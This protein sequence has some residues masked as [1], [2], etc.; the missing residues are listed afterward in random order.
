[1]R[2]NIPKYF[3]CDVDGV[4][5][6]GKYYYTST[7]KYMKIFGPHDSDGLKMIKNLVSVNFVSADK[8]GFKISKKRI[9]NDM[10]YHL[11]YVNEEDRYNYID[12]KYGLQ[13]SIY[14]GDGYYDSKILKDCLFGIVPK[15]AR[16]EAKKNSDFI[17]ESN[18]SD[19]AVLD[20]CIK[21][22]KLFFSK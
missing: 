18:G 7:G 22:I 8:R 3:I 2:K 12:K 13:N 11:A 6:D 20:A 5:T 9:T 1:M 19:G 10:G 21:I 15:N 4:M 16:K 17:T 14:M